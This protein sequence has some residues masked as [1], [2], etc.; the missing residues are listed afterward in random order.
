MNKKILNIIPG[1][2]VDVWM[3]KKRSMLPT[4]TFLGFLKHI[5]IQICYKH[6]I[7]VILETDDKEG[8][9]KEKDEEK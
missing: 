1:I 5:L 9:R 4:G 6:N 2:N 7:I 3:A 8:K